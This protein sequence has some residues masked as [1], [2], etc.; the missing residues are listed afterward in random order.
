MKSTIP[1][2]PVATTTG[3]LIRGEERDGIAVF[4]GIPYGRA[5]RFMAPEPVLPWKE[6][7]DCTKNG[8]IAMQK[9]GSISGSE[10]LGA[11]FSGGNPDR[12]GVANEVQSEDCLV[13]NVLTPGLDRAH[14]PVVVYIHG[15]G[16][17]N[18]SG[19]LVLGA[20]RWAR[21]EDLVIV[22][23][24]HRLNV[25]GY[26]PLADLDEDYADAGCAGILD[27]ILALKWVRENIS[28]FGG[29]T[30]NVTIMGESG[31]GMKVSTLLAM[32]EAKGLFHK[33]I[34]ESGSGEIGVH[35]FD[36]A[37]ASREELF[38]ALG[39]SRDRWREILTM[40]ANRIIEGTLLP[41]RQLIDFSPTADGIHIPIQL[42]GYRPSEA[43]RNIPLLVG[44]SEEELAVFMPVD[45]DI[46][47]Q[48][49]A[50]KLTA[51]NGRYSVAKYREI[52]ATLRS[53][54]ISERTPLQMFFAIVSQLH[55]LG[56]GA[57]KQA[58]AKALQ[59]GSPVFAYLVTFRSVLP[60]ALDLRFSWHTAD[61]PLQ[62]R[63]VLD[64][65]AESLSI[66]MA[67]AWAAFIRGGNPSTGDHFWAPF[68]VEG[69]ETMVFGD[70][71]AM[72]HDPLAHFR[73]LLS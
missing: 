23:V 37:V 33:A 43:S 3:G 64:P 13:L 2:C 66:A 68:T 25:F 35:T 56:N 41:H 34:V 11:Y 60:T 30:G 61:L 49:L 14:R 17:A 32:P 5:D 46:T 57:F 52:I 6:V 53:I 45:R 58:T 8:P 67:R 55:M 51:A 18:G 36:K 54:E 1:S 48:N 9:G 69:R 21:E 4:R 7:R 59:G 28:S 65:A 19:T 62:M 63:I 26:L 38:Q 39:I 16:Y 40:D 72:V 31:G 73:N 10:D 22:G 50:E 20:D 27:L 71:I 12:F 44:S 70:S 47:W 29:D 15:G 42:D 24:N